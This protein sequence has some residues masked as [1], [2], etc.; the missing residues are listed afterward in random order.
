MEEYKHGVET[1]RDASV[2][3]SVS[4]ST[5]NAQVVVGTAPINLLEDPASAVNKLVLCKK[6]SDVTE[7][8]GIS[9]DYSSYTL[10]QSAYATFKKFGVGPI[11]MINVLD[12]NNTKHVTAVAGEQF[13]VVGGVI[14]IPVKGILL[15]KIVVS[16]NDIT[17]EVDKDYVSN[18][19][20]DGN[21]VIAITEESKFKE[22]QKLTVAYT[23]LNPDGV[24]P[25]D[26][27][28]GENED[29]VSTGIALIHDIYA[30]LNIVPGIITSPKYSENPAVAAAIES[31][32]ELSG[33]IVNSIGLVDID[34]TN[35][36]K[37]EDVEKAKN[38]L[39]V[40]SRWITACWPKVLAAGGNIM[41]MS[42]MAGALLQY[43][44]LNNDNFP[45]SPDNKEFGIEGTV[46]DDGTEILLKQK[47]ANDYIVSAGVLTA[48]YLNGWKAW[49]SNTSRYPMDKNKPNMRFIKNVMMGNY[50]ENL[51]KI[52]Y[53]SSIGTDADVKLIDSV[54]NNFNMELNGNV[55][56][57]LAGAKVI[58]EKDDPETDVQEG[59]FVFTTVY[60]DY[61]PTEYIKNKFV[62]DSTILKAA[63]TGTEG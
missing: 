52:N 56:A 35:T 40:N 63:L 26:V 3:N 7:N 50:L 25:S 9:D 51:F 19:D 57:R 13:D 1:E 15:N 21:V 18:F 44:C 10:M 14:D 58:F 36:K 45:Q 6:Y 49:G 28:G 32:A 22:V 60:A 11:V 61:T 34:A 12:P 53:L 24:T 29:G 33:D 55:P 17:G 4:T 59:K 42:A 38:K 46:L 54:V 30:K 23:K 47:G 37:K 39:G 62:W 43:L 2:E 27:I 48:I 16:N 31:V 8:F 20:E 5:F 41:S